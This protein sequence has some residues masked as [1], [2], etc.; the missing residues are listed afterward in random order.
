DVV[1]RQRLDVDRLEPHRPVF[2]R[3]ISDAAEE[4]VELSGTH[5]R[6]GNTRLADQVY[7]SHLGPEVAAGQQAI[8]AHDRERHMVADAERLLGRE[9]VL[10]RGREELQ[11]G[12]ALERR[13]VGDVHYDVRPVQGAGEPG[14]GDRVYSRVW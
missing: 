3:G 2:G 6:V 12:L 9:E 1:R 10:G 5:D 8:G 7:L 13:G 4:L 11:G 14:A